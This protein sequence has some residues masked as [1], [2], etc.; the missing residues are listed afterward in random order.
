MSDNKIRKDVQ[1]RVESV[2][3]EDIARYLEVANEAKAELM[4]VFAQQRLAVDAGNTADTTRMKPLTD[5]I[6]RAFTVIA[7]LESLKLAVKESLDDVDWGLLGKS[8]V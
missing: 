1:A 3:D 8:A 5:S 4:L 6:E 7:V 2:L